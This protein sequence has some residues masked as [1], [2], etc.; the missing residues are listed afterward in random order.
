MSSTF[1]L[2]LTRLYT[3]INMNFDYSDTQQEIKA[4]VEALCARFGEDYWRQCEEDA[5]YPEDF[6][7][8]MTEAGWLAALI[9]ESYR[10]SGLALLDACLILEEVNRSGGN[11]AASPEELPSE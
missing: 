4:G 10:G 6:V 2:S 8:A 11:G 3:W 5:A 9:P 1:L 7:R